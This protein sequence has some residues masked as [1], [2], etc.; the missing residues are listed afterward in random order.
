MTLL[1]ERDR[2]TDRETDRDRQIPGDSE[3]ET[4]RHGLYGNDRLV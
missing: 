2:E 1:A 4:Q 3:T